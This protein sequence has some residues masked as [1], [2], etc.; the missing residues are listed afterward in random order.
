ME[1]CM[2]CAFAVEVKKERVVPTAGPPCLGRPENCAMCL[3]VF[4][5]QICKEGG[6]GKAE[7][8][9]VVHLEEVLPL[10]TQSTFLC[11]LETIRHHFVGLNSGVSLRQ[12]R[13]KG[14]HFATEVCRSMQD[15]T[16]LLPICCS[17]SPGLWLRVEADYT[18]KM[19]SQWVTLLAWLG[20]GKCFPWWT[21][22]CFSCPPQARSPS[23]PGKI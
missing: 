23:A 16:S 7:R 4:P 10:S 18:N 20:F 14:A 1:S 19:Q 5:Y 6:L 3:I 22:K 21:K 13:E 2:L 17:F 9:K 12:N 15:V 8:N 11:H